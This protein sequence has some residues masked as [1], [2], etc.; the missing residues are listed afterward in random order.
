MQAPRVGAIAPSAPG[1]VALY[2]H[3]FASG[4]TATA[5]DQYLIDDV[6]FR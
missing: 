6:Y 4:G 3:V 5:G 2:A 1:A